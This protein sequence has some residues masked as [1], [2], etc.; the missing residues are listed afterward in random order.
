MIAAVP[1]ARSEEDILTT[2]LWIV[3]P[4]ITAIGFTTGAY[5]SERK[6][7]SRKTGFTRLLIWPL[8]GCMVG[9]WS[10]YCF[11]PMLIVFGMLSLG[12][13]SILLRELFLFYRSP[14]QEGGSSS[15]D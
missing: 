1:A 5:L 9:A 2:A 13:I 6:L 14:A 11:G 4:V 3:A 12:A 8:I 15:G 10:V 7:L